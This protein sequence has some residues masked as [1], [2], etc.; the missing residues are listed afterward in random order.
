MALGKFDL[1]ATGKTPILDVAPD[2]WP[3]GI[4]LVDD[5]DEHAS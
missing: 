4:E 3:V 2:D 1:Q 5:E